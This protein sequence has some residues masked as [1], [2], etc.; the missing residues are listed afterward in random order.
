MTIRKG[1]E[2][3]SLAVASTAMVTVSS[4]AE[5]RALV[6]TARKGGGDIATVGLL[7]GDLMRTLGGSAQPSRFTSGE[8]VPHL[9]IDL[10]RVV[11]DDSR[12]GWFAAH[13]V[14]R[15]S[16]WRGQIVAGMNAQFINTWDVAPRCHPNDGLVDLVTAPSTMNLQQRWLARSRLPLGTHVPHPL[17]TTRQVASVV[18]DLPGK[19][20][21]WLDGQ[22]W[23]SARRITITVEPDAFVAV[24]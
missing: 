14:A 4:N 3:G 15:H 13:L 12:E 21:L 17:I 11:T 22:R 16:W 24:V 1:Q 19:T 7:G 5:L 18:L 8:P 23:G 20:P 10:V 9:P 2:W 6:E